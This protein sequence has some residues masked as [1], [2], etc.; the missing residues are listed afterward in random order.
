MVHQCRICG[1]EVKRFL[2][3]GFQP[4]ANGFLK[5][6]KEFD[7]EPFYHL[8]VCFCPNCF[9][10]QLANCPKSVDVFNKEYPFFTSTSNYMKEHLKTLAEKIKSKRSATNRFIVEIGS[11][12]GTFLEN[13][14]NEKHLGIEPSGSVSQESIKKGVDTL[15]TF[16]NESTAGW[17]ASE[18]GQA[19]II[20]STNV[21]PHIENR[22]TVLRGIKKLLAKG[23]VWINEEVYLGDIFDIVSY[24]QFYNEHIYFASLASYKKLFEQFD[25]QV[26]DYEFTNVHGGSIRFIVGHYKK[27][28]ELGLYCRMKEGILIE[29]LSSFDVFKEFG[30]EVEKSRN[31][32]LEKLLQ[33]A[34]RDEEIVGYGATAKS[35]TILNY[36][37][38]GP[39]L[40]SKIYDTTPCKQGMLSPGKHIPIVPY[41]QFD[42]DKPK[43]VVLFA[44]NHSKEIYEKEK[45]KDINWILPI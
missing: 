5:S 7:N 17:I 39:Y 25:L 23:G 9:T 29:G 14:K 16:F 3:L 12:D 1:E 8:I 44:W 43:N 40:I 34:T 10:V 41:E 21:F 32:F 27:D 19:D 37:N 36:C 6:R 33:L 42:K 26:I 28:K 18:R 38:I 11:N 20:V 35:S 4:M 2:D 30:E 13:F 22:P 31:V 24:D 15:G 45:G